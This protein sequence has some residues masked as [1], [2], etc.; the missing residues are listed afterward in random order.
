MVKIDKNKCI[1]CGACASICPDGFEMI[2]N[3]SHLKN[4]NA[5]CIKQAASSCPV[6]AIILDGEENVATE[7]KISSS[8]NEDKDMQAKEDLPSEGRGIGRGMGTGRGFGRGRGMGGH[9]LQR[10]KHMGRGNL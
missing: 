5:S 1:G 2:D 9:G 10:G 8:E 7:N 4:P 6:D 3:K